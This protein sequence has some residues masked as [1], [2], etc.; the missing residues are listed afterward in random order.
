MLGSRYMVMEDTNAGVVTPAPASP[1]AAST[2]VTIGC[3]RTSEA[4]ALDGCCA[5]R[6]LKD[7]AAAGPLWMRLIVLSGGT[8]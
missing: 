6:V 1:A 7:S 3:S 4:I 2:C 5:E 8:V